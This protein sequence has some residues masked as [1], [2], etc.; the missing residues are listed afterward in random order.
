V[1]FIAHKVRV[2]SK[3]H[4]NSLCDAF[5][6]T[7]GDIVFL[8]KCH[9]VFEHDLIETKTRGREVSQLFFYLMNL[10]FPNFIREQSCA[11]VPYDDGFL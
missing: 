8:K 6:V 9:K 1:T 10:I 11:R 7:I 4:R 3:N 5:I 2:C